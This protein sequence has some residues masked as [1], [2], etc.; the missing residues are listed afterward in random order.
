MA[1]ATTGGR[2]GGSGVPQDFLGGLFA[3]LGLPALGGVDPLAALAAGP[4]PT[5]D[6]VDV[7]GAGSGV[8]AS[9]AGTSARV[10]ASG[11]GTTAG[12]SG[13]GQNRH[14]GQASL[15]I[16]TRAAIPLG[17]SGVMARPGSDAS[18]AM[19][20]AARSLALASGLPLVL[21]SSALAPAPAPGP[22]LLPSLQQQQHRGAPSASAPPAMVAIAA[23]PPRLPL[24]S[25]ASGTV[26]IN[27]SSSDLSR[28]TGVAARGLPLPLPEGPAMQARAPA[29]APGTL[30]VTSPP[31]ATRP[32][33]THHIPQEMLLSGVEV[34][35]YGLP[36]AARLIGGGG[37]RAMAW[38][39]QR[40]PVLA[41]TS[42][43]TAMATPGRQDEASTVAEA[44]PGGDSA[45]LA[46]ATAAGQAGRPPRRAYTA[47]SSS[48]SAQRRAPQPLSMP[49]LTSSAAVGGNE[50][51]HQADVL[52]VA[53]SATGRSRVLAPGTVAGGSSAVGSA[54]ARGFFRGSGAPGAGAGAGS[55][56]AGRQSVLSSGGVGATP[57]PVRPRPAS[58]AGQSTAADAQRTAR[59]APALH[60]S[61]AGAGGGSTLARG[62]LAAPTTSPPVSQPPSRTTS[63]AA[64]AST[65]LT[66]TPTPTHHSQPPAGRSVAILEAPPQLAKD[67]GAREGMQGVTGKAGTG[68]VTCGSDGGT[69]FAAGGTA[70][71]MA[72]PGA[73]GGGGGLVDPVAMQETLRMLQRAASGATDLE[74]AL[75][76]A[77]HGIAAGHAAGSAHQHRFQPHPQHPQHFGAGRAGLGDKP[78][79]QGETLADSHM[80]VD[81]HALLPR[82]ARP[83]PAAGSGSGSGSGAGRACASRAPSLTLEPALDPAPLPL[84]LDSLTALNSAASQQQQQQLGGSSPRSSPGELF[85]GPSE[86][87][88]RAGGS[89]ALASLL[90]EG[91]SNGAVEGL[92]LTPLVVASA[93]E[94]DEVSLDR[95]RNLGMAPQQTG[96]ASQLATEETRSE[97][98]VVDTVLAAAS[99]GVDNDSDSR[100][101]GCGELQGRAC[102]QV[103]AAYTANASSHQNG[104]TRASRKHT[105]QEAH[106]PQVEELEAEGNRGVAAVAVA[107]PSDGVRRRAGS[108]FGRHQHA[109]GGACRG[110][111]AAPSHATGLDKARRVRQRVSQSPPRDIGGSRG[112]PIG[113]VVRAV[114]GVAA[115]PVRW[116]MGG[117][118]RG[119][120]GSQGRSRS[121]SADLPGTSGAQS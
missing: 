39:G 40:A 42:D 45:G 53:G 1:A 67:S 15:T 95:R 72:S 105:S 81:R 121:S 120:N 47:S 19:E 20:A 55:G 60:S 43:V 12:G 7:G 33:V 109:K 116:L 46:G 70:P 61:A 97:V 91:R 34:D 110:P 49:S 69:P 94:D 9:A 101:G 21:S 66:S 50:L 79:A 28:V 6:D 2:G 75:A 36:S 58:V 63:N 119:G 11:A 100:N 3:G 29:A 93:G 25:L 87:R 37:R 65:R 56:T 98:A 41:L 107:G 90:G 13:R 62:W 27:G 84:L 89:D 114:A 113:G 111:A 57:S 18:M 74:S 17:T 10:G 96:I 106:L 78:M 115:A 76:D 26:M 4:R 103:V 85:G 73:G 5:A 64:A 88:E 23:P 102:N 117:L 68:S 22:T 35:W 52:P 30:S 83:G 32:L 8:R 48:R 112:M 104:G 71:V 86:A 82:G 54:L 80:H 77:V 31:S 99:D 44:W 108:T 92:Q 118:L 38:W 14:P 16:M 24:P 59:P 51:S